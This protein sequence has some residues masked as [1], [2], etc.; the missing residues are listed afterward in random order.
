M[1]SPVYLNDQFVFQADK[2]EDVITKRMLTAKLETRDLPATQNLPQSLFGI[3]R[4]I[5]Q[6]LLQPIRKYSFVCLA[7]Q[8][9]PHPLPN[10]PLEGEETSKL[11]LM[12]WA[13][14][15]R[16]EGENSLST[17][18]FIPHQGDKH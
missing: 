4:F 8:D 7:A 16:G 5:P 14:E 6:R 10:P 13:G 18:S 11:A 15:S 12:P 2:I 1:L 3:S 9:L 17:P